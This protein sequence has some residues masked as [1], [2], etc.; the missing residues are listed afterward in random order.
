MASTHRPQDFPQAIE[1][2]NLQ[3]ARRVMDREE[4]Q[5]ALHSY[6]SEAAGRTYD[7]FLVDA[8]FT[9]SS[10][11]T[12]RDRRSRVGAEHTTPGTYAGNWCLWLTYDFRPAKSLA[13][14]GGTRLVLSVY[15]SALPSPRSELYR[16]PG[17]TS[18]H[19]D[20]GR[21][22]TSFDRSRASPALRAPSGWAV[23]AAQ[24]GRSTLPACNWLFAGW[25]SALP[26]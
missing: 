17:W 11:K 16:F 24:G 23:R 13:E 4:H 7:F 26:A 6:G 18:A 20:H 2:T 12:S 8:P 15:A 5:G 9:W 22:A 21:V 3:R 14:G 25:A 19:A 1:P 10:P